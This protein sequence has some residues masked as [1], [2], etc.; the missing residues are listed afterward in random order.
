MDP[1]FALVAG[2]EVSSADLG[3]KSS[4]SQTEA[5]SEKQEREPAFAR[6][7]EAAK[8]GQQAQVAPGQ[9]PS[10]ARRPANK[11]QEPA[12]PS[13]QDAK[14]LKKQASASD[15]GH[16]AASKGAAQH[17]KAKES[18]AAAAAAASGGEPHAV[19]EIDAANAEVMRAFSG[20][21]KGRSV[22]VFGSGPK[23]ATAHR[24]AGR[25]ARAARSGSAGPHAT[26]LGSAAL[27][28]S[29][30]RAAQRHTQ[31]CA[32]VAGESVH[33]SPAEA[34]T[35]HTREGPSVEAALEG[36]AAQNDSSA[37]QTASVDGG[38]TEAVE[39]AQ[40]VAADRQPMG[41]VAAGSAAAVEA[42][43]GSA[44]G[45]AGAAA[46]QGMSAAADGGGGAA[47]ETAGSL[48]DLL[49][50]N[51]HRYDL[52]FALEY[53]QIRS[54]APPTFTFSSERKTIPQSH[55]ASW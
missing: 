45:T 12:E 18:A 9:P 27:P 1:W 25:A 13:T 53:A 41:R 32:E 49:N 16:A 40:Q 48:C 47:A 4:T 22:R 31:P 38:E 46:G 8:A 55:I 44:A 36:E 29:G 3:A 52:A 2:L 15:K 50:P 20:L 34:E 30:A 26:K 7:A 28:A 10:T 6:R 19:S 23:Q 5:C 14:V 51:S 11:V 42:N 21:G 54:G 24:A 39:H 37:A 43:Q 33:I 35:D 17:G